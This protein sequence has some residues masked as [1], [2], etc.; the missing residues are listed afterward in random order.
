ME[1]EPGR[2]TGTASK[3]DGPAWGGFRVLR[4]PLMDDEPA[5]GGRRLEPQPLRIVT[6]VIRSRATTQPVKR[7]L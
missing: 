2:R 3:A 4:L 5:R 6:F 1:A 7:A